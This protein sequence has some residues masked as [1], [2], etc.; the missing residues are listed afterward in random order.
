[1]EH[2][3][4][5]CPY[6]SGNLLYILYKV[7]CKTRY[8]QYPELS[9]SVGFAP[10]LLHSRQPVRCLQPSLVQFTYDPDE[11][12]LLHRPASSIARHP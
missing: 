2:L 4:N 1:M 3:F 9:F 5:G 7:L 10:V 6:L 11:H 8:R 12:S